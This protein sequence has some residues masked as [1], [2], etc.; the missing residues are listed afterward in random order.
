MMTSLYLNNN[1]SC[2]LKQCAFFLSLKLGQNGKTSTV[3]ILIIS[4]FHIIIGG[5]KWLCSAIRNKP[6]TAQGAILLIIWNSKKKKGL[7]SFE[8]S[9]TDPIYWIYLLGA[10]SF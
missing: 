10:A 6:K 3:A 7:Q 8:S 4:E 9:V 1:R 2:Y 5:R